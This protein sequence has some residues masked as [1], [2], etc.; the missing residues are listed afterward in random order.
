MEFSK[1]KNATAFIPALAAIGL[2]LIA[3]AVASP[4]AEA[5]PVVR[6]C[7]GDNYVTHYTNFDQMRSYLD[8]VYRRDGRVWQAPND[9]AVWRLWCGATHGSAFLNGDTA[10]PN[11]IT[12]NDGTVVSFRTKSGSGGYT[13]DI[14]S[15]NHS[16]L[17]KV[18]VS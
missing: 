7:P 11:S 18:H 17:F 16:K 9:E 6:D 4:I 13:I 15:L 12:L 5:Q 3:P 2:A 10:V 8:G 14:N 1:R